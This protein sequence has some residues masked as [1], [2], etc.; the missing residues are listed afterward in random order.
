M[1]PH[2]LHATFPPLALT[3]FATDTN[4]LSQLFVMDVDVWVADVMEAEKLLPKVYP[5][6]TDTATQG[7]SRACTACRTN[8]IQTTGDFTVLP[9][10]SVARP[11]VFP[12]APDQHWLINRG[13]TKVVMYD[14]LIVLVDKSRDGGQVIDQARRF[15]S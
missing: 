13:V 15:Q 3:R 6:L 4:P 14:E 7:K 11:A 8:S 10:N 5:R 9:G 2:L 12:I 1:H